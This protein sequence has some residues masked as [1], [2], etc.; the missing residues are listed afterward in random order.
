MRTPTRHVP[1]TNAGTLVN[2]LQV[3]TVPCKL[4][5]I[6]VTN[7]KGST[8]YIQIHESASAAAEG[9]V[10][11]LPAIPIAAATFAAFD[12]GVPAGVDLSSCYICNSSTAA[13]KTIGSADCQIAAIVAG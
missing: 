7:T 1:N 12:L 6:L 10:P 13:T 5:S 11:V 2:A 9:A 3:S 4:F 8:Q